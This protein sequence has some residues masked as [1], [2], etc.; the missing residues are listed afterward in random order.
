MFRIKHLRIDTLSEHVIFIHEAAVRTG[1]LGFRPLDRVRVVE[2]GSAMGLPRE[3]TGVLNFCQDTLIAADEI[4]LSAITARDLGLPE[5]TE[6]QAT[7]APAPRSVD[8]VR[9]KL[10]GQRLDREAFDAI[11]ADVVQHRYSKVELSMF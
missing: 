2:A 3:V 11:L 7:I 10:A 4:G 1:N 9:W 8:L 6:V 5:G